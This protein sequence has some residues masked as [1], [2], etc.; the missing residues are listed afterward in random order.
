MSGARRSGLWH[1]GLRPPA[2][3]SGRSDHRADAA[4]SRHPR[5]STPRILQMLSSARRSCRASAAQPEMRGIGPAAP[6]A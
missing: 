1:Q 3:R 4:T 6:A 2:G 5:S